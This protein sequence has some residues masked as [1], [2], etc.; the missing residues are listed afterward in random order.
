[1]DKVMGG[2]PKGGSSMCSSC[3]QAHRIVGVNLQ[4][5]IYCQAKVGVSRIFFPVVECS[6]YDDKSRPSLYAMEEIAWHVTSRNRGPVGFSDESKS[7]IHIEPPDR[8]SLP[9]QSRPP[10]NE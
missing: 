3:R 4:E 2:T 8:D 5:E 9:R 10:A 7:E 1:M 6:L